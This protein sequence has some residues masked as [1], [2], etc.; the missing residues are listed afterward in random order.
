MNNFVTRYRLETNY[1]DYYYV[2]LL[3]TLRFLTD[4]CSWPL[5]KN[6]EKS[7]CFAVRV[8]GNSIVLILLGYYTIY[9]DGHRSITIVILPLL[10][11]S[12]GGLPSSSSTE[13]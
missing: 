4:P 8:Y 6:S 1:Y 2:G 11:S 7:F 9:L 5:V 10:G 12:P 3:T 13:H